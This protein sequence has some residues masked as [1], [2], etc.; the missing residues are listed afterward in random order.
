MAH[1][2]VNKCH[3]DVHQRFEKR[4]VDSVEATDLM[5][6][7]SYGSPYRCCHRLKSHNRLANGLYLE[8][9]PQPDKQTPFET[10]KLVNLSTPNTPRDNDNQ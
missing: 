7:S 8:N 9:V 6:L 3:Y 2:H 10:F 4:L 1:T 5:V